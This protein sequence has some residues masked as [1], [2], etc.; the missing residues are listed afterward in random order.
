LEKKTVHLS[1]EAWMEKIIIFQRTSFSGIMSQNWA[2]KNKV[3]VSTNQKQVV[4]L[5]LELD[6]QAPHI[7][8][9][10]S[11]LGD[12]VSIKWS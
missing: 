12:K 2:Y 7:S 5:S 6:N 1:Q 8:S 9:P 4:S 11:Y 10:G 3:H